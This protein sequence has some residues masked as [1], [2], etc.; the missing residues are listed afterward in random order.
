MSAT[1]SFKN[2]HYSG[3]LNNFSFEI[4][5][6]TC[7]LIKTAREEESLLLASLMTGLKQPDSGLINISGCSTTESN[8][9]FLLQLRSRI[10][11][12]IPSGGLVSNL[13]VWENIFL[14][15]LYHLGTPDTSDK[16]MAD[17]YLTE[18]GY[19][20]R[21]MSLPALLTPYEKRVVAFIRAAVMK[22]QIMI[23]CNVFD[24]ISALQQTGL[25]DALERYHF[26]CVGRTSIFI[27]SSADIPLKG[28]F[29]MVI[30]THGQ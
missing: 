8:H 5:M 18:L 12:I 30:A 9:D 16:E 11:V 1:I 14:P 13:K 23:Y 26:E 6:G 29:D 24:K 19:T 27:A 22:P 4:E 15:Y 20:G 7:T 28:G 21:K 25:S 10:G 17:K 2:V 3:F